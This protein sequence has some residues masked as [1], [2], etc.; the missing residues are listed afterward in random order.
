MLSVRGQGGTG[1]GPQ[2][3][4]E[5]ALVEASARLSLRNGDVLLCYNVKAA[6]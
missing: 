4:T 1:F 5:L 6:S 3:P 2:K